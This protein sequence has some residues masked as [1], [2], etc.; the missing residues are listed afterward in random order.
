MGCGMPNDQICEEWSAVSNSPAAVVVVMSSGTLARRKS[1]GWISVLLLALAAGGWLLRDRLTSSSEP[2]QNHSLERP[3]RTHVAALG[4]LEPAG[5]ILELIPGTG[6]E[7]A[8]VERLLVGEGDDV[9]AGDVLAVFDNQA[10]RRAAVQEAEA[11]LASAEARLLQVKAGAKAG[12]IAAQKS[13]VLLAEAQSKVAAR[14][15]ERAKDLE[16][17]KALTSEQLDLKRWEYDRLQ[18]EQQRAAGVLKSLEEIRTVDVQVAD[19]EVAAAAA[20]L[21]KARAEAESSELRAPQKGRVLRIHT[22]P[23]ERISDKGILELGNV[24]QMQAVAEVFEG[25]IPLISVGMPAEVRIESSDQPFTGR[26]TEIGHVVA[27]KVVL[28]NDPVSDT[29]ARVVE[30]RIQLDAE[31]QEL[32]ARLS[33]ARV[34]IRIQLKSSATTDLPES[35]QFSGQQHGPQSSGSAEPDESLK[36]VR[37]VSGR[38]AE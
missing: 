38:R 37:T 7:G 10:R 5:T 21:E 11:R 36:P 23:G 14:E 12:D 16:Q 25:D 34:E 6:N 29:D 9:E 31:F 35:T 24:R 19:K 32:V 4:R 26:V 3:Q 1:A 33:N 20:T 17:K 30:V 13:V 2:T 27:R 18:L 22:R 8:V 15:L 28:T